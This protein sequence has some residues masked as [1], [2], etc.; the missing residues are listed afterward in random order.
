MGTTT[1]AAAVVITRASTRD[2]AKEVSTRVPLEGGAS[3]TT[4]K[5]STTSTATRMEHVEGL[6][7]VDALGAIQLAGATLAV[8]IS[9]H[10]A[11]FQTTPG[12]TELAPS[13]VDVEIKQQQ[14][15]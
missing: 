5:P 15:L 4:A 6:T 8:E 14:Q 7:T 12:L 9:N 2:Q 13:M 1:I 11:G 3:A 10:L